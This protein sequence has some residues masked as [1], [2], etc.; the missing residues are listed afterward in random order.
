MGQ[1]VG[2]FFPAAF[3]MAVSSIPIIACVLVLVSSRGRVNGPVY[4]CGQVLGVATT[5]AIV[6]LAVAAGSSGDGAAPG[7]GSWLPLVVGV[8]LLALARKQWRARPRTG[9][10]PEMPGWMG[11]IDGF[12]APKALGAGF[13]LSALNPKNVILTV[14]GMASVV[15]A[16][17]PAGEQAASLAVFVVIGSLGVAAPVV[18][19]F[20]LGERAEPLLARLQDWLARNN[21]LIM[22]VILLLIGVKLIGDAIAGF[23]S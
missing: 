22:A 1:A 21:A 8:G 3:G 11:A 6:L 16:S 4:L 10:E 14:A 20:A 15:V 13:V 12:T 19:A 7:A 2:D 23:S 18:I 9:E 5:G 17:L